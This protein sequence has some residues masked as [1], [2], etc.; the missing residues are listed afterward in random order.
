MDVSLPMKEPAFIADGTGYKVKKFDFSKMVRFD[1]Y[2]IT[3]LVE[4]IVVAGAEN[5]PLMLEKSMYDSWVNRIHL[6]IKGKKNGRMILDSI[7]NGLLV[8]PII[9]ENRQ[10]GPKQYSELTEAQQLQD[11]YEVQETSI[12][13]HGLPPDMY[14]LQVQVNTKFLNALLREWSKFVTNV[15][16]T[17][18]LYTTN[19]DQLYAYLS[20]HERH[21][22]ETIPQNSAFQT[23]DLDA[24][25]L[26]CDNISSAKAVLMANLS[27]YDSDVL[28]EIPYSNT[29][30]NDKI[31]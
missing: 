4:H 13:L 5:H 16:L 9:K 22:N 18:I 19:Y 10:T 11:D 14:A 21:A 31:Y 25:D 1:K 3:T 26:D 30:L 24:Y 2:K 12:I 8:Y 29:Y 27:S 15:K 6:F 28:S 23:K 7:D 17:K 20:H